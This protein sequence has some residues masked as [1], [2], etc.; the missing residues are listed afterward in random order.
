LSTI[1]SGRST[2]M[3]AARSM[4]AS[5]PPQMMVSGAPRVGNGSL[6]SVDY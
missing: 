6:A 5:T 3:L 1:V 4:N 2:T